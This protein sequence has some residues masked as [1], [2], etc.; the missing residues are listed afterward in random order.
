MN[1]AEVALHHL[2]PDQVKRRVNRNPVETVGPH[3]ITKESWVVGRRCLNHEGH[4][5]QSE[6]RSER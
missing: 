4:E 1:E 2:G 6:K 5:E 3:C